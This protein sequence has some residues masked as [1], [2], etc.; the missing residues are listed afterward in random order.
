MI[1][2]PVHVTENGGGG[3]PQ[4]LRRACFKMKMKSRETKTDRRK[5]RG[6]SKKKPN[7][8]TQTRIN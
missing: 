4:R 2:G 8:Q 3:G 7:K 6:I 1:I 5:D